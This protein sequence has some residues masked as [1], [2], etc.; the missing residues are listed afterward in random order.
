MSTVNGVAVDEGAQPGQPPRWLASGG[1]DGYLFI[2]DP[3]NWKAPMTKLRG[4][5]NSEQGASSGESEARPGARSGKWEGET[6]GASMLN[7]VTCLAGGP[8]G[9]WL[10]AA[11]ETVVR[12]WHRKDGMWVGGKEL[13]GEGLGGVASLTVVD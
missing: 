2:W 6:A 1:G 11:G 10:L 12:A 3:R 9:E 5:D 8:G 7:S 13:P 4:V